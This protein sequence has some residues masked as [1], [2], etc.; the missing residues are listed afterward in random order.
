MNDSTER[1]LPTV[2]WTIGDII[3]AVILLAF[4]IIVLN[5]SLL[6]VVAVQSW[7]GNAAM[8]SELQRS[9]L[10]IG[11]TLIGGE[12]LFFLAAWL[13]S[14][15]KYG[16]DWK[17]LGYRVFPSSRGLSLAIV[18]VVFCLAVNVVY[19]LILNAL[20]RQDLIPRQ[21]V[22]DQLGRGPL[23]VAILFLAASVAA[24]LAEETFFRGFLFPGLARRLGTILAAVICAAA[25]AAAHFEIGALAPIFVLG[26]ALTWLYY[27][28]RS[29]WPSILVHASYNTLAVLATLLVQQG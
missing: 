12:A 27:E 16:G 5:V 18:V 23:G 2:P 9:P 6:A 1:K 20:G 11:P 7:L 3:R 8:F 29:L 4:G 19:G 10:V 17:L 15:R 25:F 21:P 24:P 26:L 14:V 13:F 22:L 28:T